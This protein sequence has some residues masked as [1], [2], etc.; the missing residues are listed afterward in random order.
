MWRTLAVRHPDRVGVLVGFNEALAHLIEAGADLFIMPS[1]FEPCGLNQMYSQRY[2]T[3]PVVR[4]TGGL[5][6]T[7]EQVDHATGIGTGFKFQA[8][9]A[10]ALVA[11]LR[12]ALQWYGRPESWRLIQQRGMGRD[13]SWDASA[14]EYVKAYDRARA[15]RAAG[16]AG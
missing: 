9:T 10:E 1:R 3:V 2:G 11:T 12:Y 6:D 13:F 7:V 8:P 14:R 4:A 5:D 16:G 15:T